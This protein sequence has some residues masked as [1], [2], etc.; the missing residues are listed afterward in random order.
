MRPLILSRLAR[1]PLFAS[2]STA[3]L[4]MLSSRCVRCCCPLVLP[5]QLGREETMQ[6]FIKML[7]EQYGGVKEYVQRACNL[8][9]QD[10]IIIRQNL[11]TPKL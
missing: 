8:T 1:E 5:D 4:N 10:I 11:R 3:A 7:G 9:D 6:A 2:D